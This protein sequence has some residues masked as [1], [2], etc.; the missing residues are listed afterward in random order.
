M[1]LLLLLAVVGAAK[2]DA[3]VQREVHPPAW[4]WSEKLRSGQVVVEPSS[5]NG[6]TDAGGALI[7]DWTG[8]AFIPGVN[9]AQAV[10]FLQDYP[11]HMQYY[12][13]EVVETRLVS[14]DG[15]NWVIHYRLAKHYIITVV[16][17]V[18][19]T[20]HYDPLS[21]TRM[22]SRSVATRIVEVHAK[23]G[24]D[25]GFLWRLNTW[26][27]LEEKDGGVYVGCRMISLTRSPPVGLGWLINPLIRTLPR[28]S[29]ARLLTATRTAVL[30]RA[31]RE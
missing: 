27:T 8:A 7:H 13:P 24:H 6:I 2:Y 19:Q 18:D 23:P 20:V 28:D 21:A 4:Q 29:L 30:A 14:H 9:L 31:K 17:D 22:T 25:H 16:L 15:N 1:T 3:Y 12:R 10:S 5:G 11:T 26:W